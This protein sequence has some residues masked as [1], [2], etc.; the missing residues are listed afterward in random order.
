MAENE[1]RR[2]LATWTTYSADVVEEWCCRK[3]CEDAVR[4]S[5][6]GCALARVV[7]VPKKGAKR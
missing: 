4:R 3:D 2:D 1:V 6:G 5:E 7:A